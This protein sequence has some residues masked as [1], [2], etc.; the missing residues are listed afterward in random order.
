[1]N[2]TNIEIYCNSFGPISHGIVTNGIC[3]PHTPRRADKDLHVGLY[4]SW[5]ILQKRGFLI[6]P[7]VIIVLA[8]SDWQYCLQPHFT[9]M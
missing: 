3:Q 7:L 4:R 5:G 9:A 6:D 2:L 8:L 1:M